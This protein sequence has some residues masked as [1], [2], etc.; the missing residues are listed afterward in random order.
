MA[1][2]RRYSYYDIFP[3]S[4][5]KEAKGGIKSHSRKGAFASSWWGKRWI[6]TLES[7]KIGARLDRG[8]TYARKG[9]VLSIDIEKGV[10]HAK[11]QG[12]RS[13]PYKVQ[14]KVTEIK[15]AEWKKLIDVLKQKPIFA[16]KLLAGEIPDD[17]EYEFHALGLSLF[18]TKAV[19][20]VTECSCPDWSNPCKHIAAVFYLLGEEFDRD[21]FLIFTMRGM[22]RDE[23]LQQ[24]NKDGKRI[25]QDSA[26]AI[27]NPIAEPLPVEAD[28]FWRGTVN[29]KILD[30]FKTIEQPSAAAAQPKRL[31]NFPFWRGERPFMDYLDETYRRASQTGI[32]LVIGD[33]FSEE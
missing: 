31:G 2:Y 26:P 13:T 8:R 3:T 4:K 22:T 33:L 6:Q 18:P 21:P 30:S 15:D 23:F 25:S 32:E 17:I 28:T 16:A 5:P 14:I 7:F 12:S 29:E 9:Q 27:A 1:R 24:L 19:D 10:I 11:V 20:L